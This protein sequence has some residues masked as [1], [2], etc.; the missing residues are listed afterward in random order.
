VTLAGAR[1]RSVW[2][3]GTGGASYY[4]VDGSARLQLA[5][6]TA[7]SLNASRPTATGSG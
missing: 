5:T 6:G 4:G 7:S 1:Y 3:V 2:A